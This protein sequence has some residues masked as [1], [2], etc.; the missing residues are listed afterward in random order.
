MNT[1]LTFT[2]SLVY[3]DHP[4]GIVIPVTLAYAGTTIIVDAK[5]DTGAEVC[6]FSRQAGER[7]GLCIEAGEPIRLSTL[8]GTIDAFGHE[9]GL[10]TGNLT[11]YSTVYFAKHHGLP[12]NLLGRIGWLRNIKLAVVDYDNTLYLSLY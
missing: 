9:V 8:T 7:V 4:A 6:L 11:F 12:R 2:E 5:I 3:P 10:H 1:Q